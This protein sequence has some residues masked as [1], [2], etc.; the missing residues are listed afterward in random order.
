[1]SEKYITTWYHY[2]S[3]IH[4]RDLSSSYPQSMVQGHKGHFVVLIPRDWNLVILVCN[5][6][7]RSLNKCS[8][9]CKEPRSYCL[10]NFGI[11]ALKGAR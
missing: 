5:K 1:M 6:V 2:P 8:N 7:N 10:A 9:V 11:W 4:S 3:L